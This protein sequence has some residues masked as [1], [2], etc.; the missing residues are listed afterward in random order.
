MLLIAGINLIKVGLVYNSGHASFTTKDYSGNDVTCYGYYSSGQRWYNFNPAN[1]TG[2]SSD[3]SEYQMRSSL[4]NI[5][6]NNYCYYG[7][8]V[9]SVGAGS[10]CGVI[11]GDGDTAPTIDDY[12]LAG[13]IITD[14]TATSS[15]SSS[16]S[17]GKAIATGTYSITNTGAVAFTIREIGLSRANTNSSSVRVLLTRDVLQ[18][19]ITIDPGD[20][21]SLIYTIEIG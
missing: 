2:I 21:K 7:L 12:C 14:F 13:N 15:I 11:I 4:Y 6:N 8:N 5:S 10:K 9:S 19:P 1:N 20:T 16:I 18:T 3:N 17:N